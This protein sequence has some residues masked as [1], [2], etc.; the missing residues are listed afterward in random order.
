[1]TNKVKA[2]IDRTIIILLAVVFIVQQVTHWEPLTVLLGC[3]V[4]AAIVLLLFQLKGAT[5]WLTAAFV[6]GGVLLMLLQ[7]ADALYWF[8]SASINVT[9]VTLFVF[10]PLF[11]IPVRLP[12]YVEALKRFYQANVRSKTALFAGTQLLTQI[13][14]AFI[15][16]GSIPVVYHLT[17]V[18][19][20]PGIMTRLLV[21]AMN[22]GFG[23]AILWSPYFA[24]MTIVTSSLSLYWSSLLP[25]VLG[26][27]LLSVL[28]SWAVDFRWL[29]ES[30]NEEEETA[31]SERERPDANRERA[32]F[33]AGLGMYLLLA[34][35]AVLLL[36]RLIDL[37][38][39][40]IT[41]MAAVLFPL[42][43]CL[44]KGAMA[45]YR[46]GLTNHFTVTL[47][48]LQK[49]I[50]LFL[51]AGFFSGSISATGFGASVPALLDAV[52]L[53]ISLSFSIAAIALIAATSLIGI[54][55]IVPVTVL[56]TGIDPSAVHISPV[57]FGVLLLGGWGLSN[58]ISPVSAVNNLLA[59]ILQK[60]V[61]E[62]A[63]P[64]YKY[65]AVM[66]VILLL[67]LSAGLF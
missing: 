50:A 51:A 26:L 5:L 13:M 27:A 15:N 58:P 37:P 12:A 62:L 65:A 59:G 4:F 38:M 34:I 47:P 40:L 56:A 33:P 21:N 6:A 36:E 61:V 49:E 60:S 55:P 23:G 2:A 1:M 45:T 57:Y 43:W 20:Q 46:Q 32:G 10:A 11:G 42:A 63:R 54:H 66:A 52:P 29:R 53:P 30:R 25:Y 8:E 18:K 19:P 67:F 16:V 28:V 24:A 22:R 41:C 39:V 7:K 17:F 64:N 9:L 31:S 48:A 3:M 35:A 44:G 14:G